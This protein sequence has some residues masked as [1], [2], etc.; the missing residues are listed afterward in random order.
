MVLRIHLALR[1]Q[2]PLVAG[3]G[4]LSRLLPRLGKDRKKDGGEDGYYGYDDK[5][6]NQC[7]SLHSINVYFHLESPLSYK[8]MFLISL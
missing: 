2:L 3:T 8:K 6:L 5:K 7:E 4:S 1:R